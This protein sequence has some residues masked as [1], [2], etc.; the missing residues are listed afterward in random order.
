[1]HTTLDH[2][3]EQLEPSDDPVS[4]IGPTTPAQWL[5]A[6]LAVLFLGGALGYMV[7]T[8][9]TAPP[10]ADSLDVGFLQDMISHHEQALQMAALDL[11]NGSEL[12]VQVFAQEI[13]QTQSYEI[14]LMERQLNQWG[15]DRAARPDTAMGWMGMPIPVAAMPGM[16]SDADLRRLREGDGRE[17]DTRFVWLMQAHHRGG[18]HMAEYA[19]REAESP[20]VRQLA[21][22]VE[23]NQRIEINELEAALVRTG[24]DQLPR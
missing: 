4:T 16:A 23:R 5:A 24:L 6:V 3:D 21:T 2:H 12:G 19:A 18:V 20:F 17:V 7:G 13:L 22:R 11:A 9:E 15:H 1:M 14:G 10:G 8:R